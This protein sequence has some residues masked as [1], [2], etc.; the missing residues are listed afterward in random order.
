MDFPQL[1]PDSPIFQPIFINN[2]SIFSPTIFSVLFFF[3]QTG[4]ELF[5]GLAPLAP[6][7][8]PAVFRSRPGPKEYGGQ[9][10]CYDAGES[11]G[12]LVFQ[13]THVNKNEL[14]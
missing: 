5:E 4:G 9:G 1:I 14:R 10:R 2:I 8:L 13:P 6:P 12:W 3:H 7:R 11:L